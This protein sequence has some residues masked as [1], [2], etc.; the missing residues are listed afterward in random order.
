MDRSVFLQELAVFAHDN[1]REMP[2]REA[3][4]K[5]LFDVY[6]ILVSEVMLQQTQ[7]SRVLPKYKEFLTRFPTV[8]AL[9]EA[10]LADVL[11]A[12]QGLGYN[13]RAKYLWQA[14]QQIVFHG[15]GVFPRQQKELAMLPGIGANT[16]GAICAYAFNQP[17]VFIET[18]IRTVFIHEFFRHSEHVHDKEIVTMLSDILVHV[19]AFFDSYREFYWALMDY[20]VYLKSTIG[21]A[22]R[23]SRHYAKQSMFEGS[24]RQVRGVVLRLLANSGELSF[25]A[26][27]KKCT[28]NRLKSVVEDL[29]KEGL[30]VQKNG[31][32]CLP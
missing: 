14:A 22:S 12:W 2:W 29:E 21:N 32:F 26:I 7:V 27:R 3:N 1:F 17:V 8:R 20:G 6:A 10:K 19:P 5:G 24:R 13:R 15:E 11:V 30:I 28:D 18:N 4:D 23:S 31:L 16:A 9:A 25:A